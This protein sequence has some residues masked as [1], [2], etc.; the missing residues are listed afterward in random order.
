MKTILLSIAVLACVTVQGQSSLSYTC[1]ISDNGKMAISAGFNDDGK[2][3]HVKY[4][5]QKDSIVLKFIKEVQVPEGYKTIT[6][7]IYNEYLKG[8]LNG[9]YV[10]DDY[11]GMGASLTYTRKKDKK[12]FEFHLDR[13]RDENFEFTNRATPCY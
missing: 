11:W 12:K 3:V 4:R 1:F 2:I 10:Y 8:K 13:E 5:G 6:R 9:I 7:Q